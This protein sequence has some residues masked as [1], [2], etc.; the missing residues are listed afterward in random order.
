M[1][2]WECDRIDVGFPAKYNDNYI[3]V[4]SGIDVFSIFL[5]L[6]HVRSKT[7]KA[8][9]LAFLYIFKNTKYS[10]TRRRRRRHVRLRT[11]KGKEF[12]NSQFQAA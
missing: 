7:G 4:I 2:V 8:V 1:F 5:L 10:K 12:L 11:D 9:T 6:V 3:Y